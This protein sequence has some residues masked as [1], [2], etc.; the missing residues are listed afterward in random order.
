[1]FGSQQTAAVSVSSGFSGGA[2]SG[3]GGSS[4]AAPSFGSTSSGGF[5]SFGASSS[6]QPA[7]NQ[8]VA[9]V[10]VST[11]PKTFAFGSSIGTAAPASGVFAF[12]AS[13]LAIQAPAA[14]G[15]F[16]FGQQQQQPAGSLFGGVGAAADIGLK[17]SASSTDMT[18][19]KKSK[20]G[21]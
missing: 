20:E 3:F 18:A 9:A 12:G 7:T 13:T 15:L 5:S 14:G 16:A 8:F 2:F 6:Q 1:M 19:G 11:A 4:A 17:R 10:T 21:V